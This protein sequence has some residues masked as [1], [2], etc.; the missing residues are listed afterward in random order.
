[1]RKLQLEEVRPDAGS[2]FKILNPR[3]S[4]TFLWH[5]HPEYEIVYAEALAGPRHVGGHISRYEGSDLVFIGPNIP[6]LNFD[7]GVHTP[8]EQVVIQMRENF[9]GEPFF[10]NP[11][12]AAIKQ[13]FKNACYG[14]AFFGE[15][16][17]KATALLKSLQQLNRFEQLLALLQIF[18]LLAT[19]SEVEILNGS[20]A[21][22]KA[23]EK[24]RTRMDVI[25]QYVEQNYNGRPD[26][27]ELA[28]KVNLSTAA[29]CRYFK[30][31]TS[32][33]FTDFVNQYRVSEAKNLLMQ[34]KTVAEACYA[35]GFEQLSYFNRAFKKI[36]GENPSSF[37]KR[38]LS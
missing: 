29:F 4:T 3:L 14:L 24:Q 22:N 13:L 18:Q 7:Y 17:T 12:M 8:C 16:K 32:K 36:T 34:D 37:K 6:H 30:R 19:S 23:F 35:T 10:N 5:L 1:M 26:V 38:I 11:E 28:E 9:L 31:Q 21:G 33:T 20:P 27:N 2:S 25:Y 15:T